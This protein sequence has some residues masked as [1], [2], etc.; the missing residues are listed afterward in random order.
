M[1]MENTQPK[2]RSKHRSIT[3]VLL[4][5]L[6]AA[7]GSTVASAIYLWT[8]QTVTR[9]ITIEGVNAI[10]LDFS[11]FANYG[12]RVPVTSLSNSFGD[13][14]DDSFALAIDN[15]YLSGDLLIKVMVNGVPSG[16]NVTI[17]MAW[18]VVY[19]TIADTI[20]LFDDSGVWQRGYNASGYHSVDW[21]PYRTIIANGTT[22]IPQAQ[23]QRLM[24]EI[25]TY[26]PSIE[27]A[28]GILLHFE[29]KQTNT[30]PQNL[31]GPHALSIVVKIGKP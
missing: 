13:C 23:I 15:L 24:Y 30:P 14:R 7:I 25:R 22:L 1:K 19:T 2:S 21:T 6:L 20:S 29:F 5:I 11:A 12:N 3:L 17:K 27:D 18:L 8:S 10:A 4:T 28:N 9:T 31:W 16:I 26:S